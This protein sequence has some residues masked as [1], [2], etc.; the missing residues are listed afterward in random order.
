MAEACAKKERLTAANCVGNAAMTSEFR[1]NEPQLLATTSPEARAV[2]K[3]SDNCVN[4][5]LGTGPEI[6]NGVNGKLQSGDN[7]RLCKASFLSKFQAVMETA[8]KRSIVPRHA[9]TLDTRSLSKMSYSE[10]KKASTAY[11]ARK[12]AMVASLDQSGLGKWMN[13]PQEIDMFYSK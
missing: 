13:K 3:T 1:I 9:S 12:S 10:L 6:L 7:S 5:I 8:V 4:W 2:W 11:Q